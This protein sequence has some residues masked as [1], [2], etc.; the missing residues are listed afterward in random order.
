MSSF[1]INTIHNNLVPLISFNNDAARPWAACT[2][3][4]YQANFQEPD[5]SSG[6]P[7]D[8]PLNLGESDEYY[9]DEEI[10]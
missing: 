8:T 5:N 7:V 6:L 10:M 1:F 2:L 3:Y 4:T 9:T